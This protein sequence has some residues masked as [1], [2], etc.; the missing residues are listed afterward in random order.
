MVDS[1]GWETLKHASSKRTQ[2]V[3]HLHDMVTKDLKVPAE[4]HKQIIHLGVGEPSI[5]TG[6]E[7]PLEITKSVVDG[8]ES[9]Q[10]NGYTYLSG[11]NAAKQ[12]I[13]DKYSKSERPFTVSD[14]FVAS[15]CGGA[16]HNLF[17]VMC[18]PG[19]NI[20]VPRPGWAGWY[21]FA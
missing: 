14:V 11:S 20:L 15:G 12:A 1:T 19:D 21:T 3:N 7:F 6:F 18:D 4:P 16:L 17:S 8:V 5:K 2:I 9:H 10:Y 13:V